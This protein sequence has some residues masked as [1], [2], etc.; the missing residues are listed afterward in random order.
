V[1][2]RTREIGIRMEVGAGTPDIV[3]L[4]P[5]E[6]MALTL[7]GVGIGIAGRSAARV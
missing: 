2:L 1:V 3:K 7:S 5:F 6:A 4:I